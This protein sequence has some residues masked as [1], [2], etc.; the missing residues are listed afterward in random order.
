MISLPLSVELARSLFCGL[1]HKESRV[2]VVLAASDE[3]YQDVFVNAGLIAPLKYWDTIF[4]RDW[5]RRVLQGNPTLEYL[6]MTDIRS[7]KWRARVGISDDDADARV[8]R[9]VQLLCQ[10][11]D[12]CWVGFEFS[13]ARFNSALK[14]PMQIPTGARKQFVAEYFGFVGYVLIV[15]Q[16]VRALYPSTKKVDFLVE[17]NGEVTKNLGWFYDEIENF[18]RDSGS[19]ELSLMGEIIPGSKDRTPLQAADVLC[20]H[21]RRGREN[22]LTGKDEQRYERLSQKR[23]TLG[24]LE[25]VYL[26]EIQARFERKRNGEAIE[27]VHEVRQHDEA[28]IESST[29]QD[30][31]GTGRREGSKKAEG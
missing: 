3:T 14:Q 19:D 16:H 25:N 13:R 18:L 11:R 5:D 22:T 21:V 4:A 6:H 31:G 1:Q 17:R 20:W 15:L 29:R 9:A 26:D 7:P 24:F 8:E 23:A 2:A 10:R 30:Q 27:R 28:T 12:P